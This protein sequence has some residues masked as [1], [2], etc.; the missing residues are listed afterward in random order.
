MIDFAVDLQTSGYV[1]GAAP[2]ATSMPSSSLITTP[3]LKPSGSEGAQCMIREDHL[4]LQAQR[5]QVFVFEAHVVDKANSVADD[6]YGA[7]MPEKAEQ[8]AQACCGAT[9]LQR[10]PY[11]A[12][13][14]PNVRIVDTPPIGGS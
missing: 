14:I 4:N 1:A 13:V 11:L 10:I 9:L 2:A 6:M 12:Q 8:P 5:V 7:V 3:R